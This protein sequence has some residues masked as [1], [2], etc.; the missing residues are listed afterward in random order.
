MKKSYWSTIPAPV[1]YDQV[2]PPNAKLLYGEISALLNEDGYCEEPNQYF[3]E[4]FQFSERTVNRLLSAL[5]QR[6]Y[7]RTETEHGER[8]SVKQRKIYAGLNLVKKDDS[9]GTKLSEL[10]RAGTK[11]SESWDKIVR[12]HFIKNNIYI[13][14]ISPKLKI[15]REVLE[16]ILLFCDQDLDLFQAWMEFAEMRQ[17]I[18]KPIT[19]VGTVTR[20]GNKLRRFSKGDPAYMIGMLG[21]AVDNKWQSL[22]EL[23]PGDDGYKASAATQRQERRLQAW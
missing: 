19:T 23:E 13:P 7:I 8:F 4:L 1:R 21:K 2:I 12:A 10:T 14:P 18:K 11:L 22:Y 5:E 6:G 17:E 3:C 9:A 20:A 15:S 16:A